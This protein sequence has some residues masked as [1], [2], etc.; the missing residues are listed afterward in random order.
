MKPLSSKKEMEEKSSMN[1]KEVKCN[2]EESSA[3]HS[4]SQICFEHERAEN[5][6]R[7]MIALEFKDSHNLAANFIKDENIKKELELITSK[8]ESIF[9]GI[10]A[11]CR[12]EGCDIHALNNELEIIKHFQE[13]EKVE[14]DF[15]VARDL[16][17]TI[18]ESVIAIIVFNT[19]NVLLYVNGIL[20]VVK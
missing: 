9:L 14:P 19:H 6:A 20:E 12:I 7:K 18:D 13:S 3:C 10:V 4:I 5:L 16:A 15:Q 8:A 11:R 1:D 2:E 17:K